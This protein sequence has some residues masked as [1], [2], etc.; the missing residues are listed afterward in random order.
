MSDENGRDQIAVYEP[1]ETAPSTA[2]L[3]GGIVGDIQ[4][5][6]RKE[7]SLARQEMR[8]EFAK[9]KS[10][11]V[12]LVAGG[13]V[14]VI[15]ILF[16]LIG[17]AQGAALLLEWPSWAGFAALGGILFGIGAILAILAVRRFASFNPIPEKTV[18][19]VKENV[20]W[21]KERTIART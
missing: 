18:E 1:P 10:A 19:T 16:L 17:L 3:L 9:L 13:A 2:K 14:L 11:A 5:L 6:L 7:V 21:L 12:G 8:E 4:D 15:G 20:E